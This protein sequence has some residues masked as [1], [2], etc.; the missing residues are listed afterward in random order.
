M[1][2]MQEIHCFYGLIVQSSL[3]RKFTFRTLFQSGDTDSLFEI[4]V[5]KSSLFRH[6][7]R[8]KW[9]RKAYRTH[10]CHYILHYD[11]S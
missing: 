7:D 4:R 11:A 5:A 9:H 10:V 2:P 8:V 1:T 3:E 6:F